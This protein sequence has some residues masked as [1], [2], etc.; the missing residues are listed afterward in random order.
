[1]AGIADFCV[2]VSV[3]FYVV[4]ILCRCVGNE[5]FYLGRLLLKSMFAKL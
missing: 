5:L 2:C 3:Y 1:M 4:F